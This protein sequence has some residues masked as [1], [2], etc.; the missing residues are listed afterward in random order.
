[1]HV[2]F[3][4]R[5]FCFSSSSHFPIRIALE[6]WESESKGERTKHTLSCLCLIEKHSHSFLTLPTRD[7]VWKEILT[8]LK[9]DRSEQTGKVLKYHNW[10]RK[11]QETVSETVYF[12]IP[13]RRGERYRM[14]LPSI[15]VQWWWRCCVCLPT[16][17]IRLLSLSEVIILR[18]PCPWPH[19]FYCVTDREKSADIH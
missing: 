9:M 5:S 8:D 14:F 13:Q 17:C 10:G 18:L 4:C 6:L 2:H 12:S 16:K 19:L 11:S 7:R 1:M 15:S 3:R